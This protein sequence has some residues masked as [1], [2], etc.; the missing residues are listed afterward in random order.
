MNAF[1]KNVGLRI[2]IVEDDLLQLQAL[3]KI[4][5]T[6]HPNTIVIGI[7]DN[8]NDAILLCSDTRPDLV[9]LD[10]EL[11]IDQTFETGLSLIEKLEK[12][13]FMPNIAIFT[14]FFEKYAVKSNLIRE[15][16]LNKPIYFLSKPYQL[17]K[18]NDVVNIV[19]L[20]IVNNL[21]QPFTFNI[22]HEA[23]FVPYYEIIKIR[24]IGDNKCQIRYFKNEVI[25]EIEFSAQFPKVTER[26]LLIENF[27]L[28]RKAELVNVYHIR[29]FEV[30]KKLQKITIPHISEK[31]EKIVVS[32]NMAPLWRKKYGINRAKKE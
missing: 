13:S 17:S 4:L 7:A 11:K 9:F 29:N 19:K 10:I 16:L 6:Y 32:E 8:V 12:Q 15:R 23:F 2:V 27:M 5:N 26:L 30:N 18:I 28:I 21:N 25:K 22:Y 14:S 3:I 20:N 31:V 24:R 1:F